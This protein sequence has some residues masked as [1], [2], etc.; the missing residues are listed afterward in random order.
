MY[1][2]AYTVHE[3]FMYMINSTK[4]QTKNRELH[5]KMHI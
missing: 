4:F 3:K 5:V 2:Y 1:K